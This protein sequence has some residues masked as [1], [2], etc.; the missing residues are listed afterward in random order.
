MHI[1]DIDTVAIAIGLTTADEVLEITHPLAEAAVRKFLRF[2]PMQ[3]QRVEY[4]PI[5]SNAQHTTRGDYSQWDSRNG[6]AVITDYSGVGGDIITLKHTPVADD[7]T[8][9]V[10]ENYD[11]R[12]GQNSG[13]FGSTTVLTQGTQYWLD[14]DETTGFSLSGSLVRVGGNWPRDP[15]S[16]KVTYNGGFTRD[17]IDGNDPDFVCPAAAAIKL[18]AI[19]THIAVYRSFKLLGKQGDS[20]GLVAGPITSESIDGY[21]YSISPVAQSFNASVPPDAANHL[22]PF[23]SYSGLLS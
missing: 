21:S 20:V 23:R 19:I 6:K 12:A 13:S 16:V 7:N 2:D 8:L 22:Q 9:E 5:L 14:T 10:R 4:Y 3:R 15:R 1:V 17:Q 18:G 11:A